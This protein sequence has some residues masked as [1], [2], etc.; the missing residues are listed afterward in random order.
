MRGNMMDLAIGVIIGT[1][2][3]KIIDSLVKD[4]IMPPFS[5]LLGSIDFADKAIVLKQATD[6]AKAIT[7]NYGLFLNTIISFLIIA[8]SIFLVVKQINR[9]RKK[10]ENE[11]ADAEDPQDIK[12][13]KEIRDLLKSQNNL[14]KE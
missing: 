8:V 14:T 2:F 12:V 3:G 13:L 7:L 1:A 9:F 10:E 4:I 11:K 6:S 5:M